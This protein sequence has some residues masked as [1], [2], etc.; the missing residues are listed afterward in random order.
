MLDSLEKVKS[1][2]NKFKT[3]EI[4]KSAIQPVAGRGSSKAKIILIGEAPGKKEDEL[5][6]PFVGRS[7]KLLSELIASINMSEEEDFYITNIVKFR[8]PENRDPTKEEKEACIPFLVR[9]IQIIKP[10]IIA[11]LGRHSL[12]FFIPKAQISKVHGQSFTQKETWNPEQIYFPLY[13][14]AVALYNPK[15]KQILFED[16]NQLKQVISKYEL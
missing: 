1:D 8:P 2:L 5:G 14:P 7:G 16:F 4:T 3:L 12:N 15:Q 6:L 13:H 9:E 11:T 10:I